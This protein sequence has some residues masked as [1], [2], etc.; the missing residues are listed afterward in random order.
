MHGRCGDGVG[1]FGRC[2]P[3]YEVEND[4][5]QLEQTYFSSEGVITEGQEL[6]GFLRAL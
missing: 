4:G 5:I 3:S 1:R 6:V 2:N